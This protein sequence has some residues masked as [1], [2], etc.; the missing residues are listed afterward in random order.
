MAGC[1]HCGRD[2]NGFVELG[3]VGY[4]R[5]SKGCC[6]HCGNY[7]SGLGFKQSTRPRTVSNQEYDENSRKSLDYAR[8]DVYLTT[9]GSLAILV[10]TNLKWWGILIA[11]VYLAIFSF[12]SW[13]YYVD[14]SFILNRRYTEADLKSPFLHWFVTCLN[15]LLWAIPVLTLFSQI[16]TTT[17]STVLRDIFLAI[18][19][20]VTSIPPLG[21]A[22]YCLGELVIYILERIL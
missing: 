5:V 6:P 10:V 15:L 12:I 20:I 21:F 18:I 17:A 14:N 13:A 19:I 8:N 3:S 4:Q 11:L 1:P 2:L 16:D 9:L 7:V 22:M